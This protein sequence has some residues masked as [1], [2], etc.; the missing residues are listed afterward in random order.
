M[1]KISNP[2]NIKEY[3]C[4]FR[5]HAAQKTTIKNYLK[6]YY[7]LVSIFLHEKALMGLFRKT[8]KLLRSFIK[9]E[10]KKILIYLRI[11]DNKF[12]NI[13]FSSRNIR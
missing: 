13:P 11:I 2:V 6:Q 7:E 1:A 9:W 4:V 8:F 5:V 12:S 3:F 10:V